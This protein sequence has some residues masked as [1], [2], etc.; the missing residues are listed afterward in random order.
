MPK[1]T[2]FGPRP[3][4]IRPGLA[5]ATTWD[6]SGPA[7]HTRCVHVGGTRGCMYTGAVTP[8]CPF[9]LQCS[10]LARYCTRLYVCPPVPVVLST[11]M[12]CVLCCARQGCRRGATYVRSSP[13]Y[14]PSD[15][16]VSCRA[17][18]EGNPNAKSGPEWIRPLP[19]SV[20][21]KVWCDQDTDGGE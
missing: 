5:A 13:P 21:V 3:R 7:L 6:A 18:K 4:V 20:A 9:F 10:G 14:L 19:S 8:V 11:L 17:I 12:F 1:S 16:P 15:A 2:S